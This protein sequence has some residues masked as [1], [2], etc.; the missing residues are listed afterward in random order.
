LRTWDAL[1]RLL[2][3]KCLV[4]GGLASKSGMAILVASSVD[5]LLAEDVRTFGAR[6]TTRQMT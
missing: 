2:H 1:K 4:R 5:R 3:V 6:R